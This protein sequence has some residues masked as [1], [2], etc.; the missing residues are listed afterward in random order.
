MTYKSSDIYQLRRW[1]AMDELFRRRPYKYSRLEMD[2]KLKEIYAIGVSRDTFYKDINSLNSIFN[3][4]IQIIN[5]LDSKK[6][7]YEDHRQSILN[8]SIDRDSSNHLRLLLKLVKDDLEQPVFD[9]TKAIIDAICNYE[10]TDLEITEADISKKHDKSIILGNDVPENKIFFNEIFSAITTKQALRITYQ[11]F[12]KEAEIKTL[13]PLGFKKHNNNWYFI[14]RDHSIDDKKNPKIYKLS[15]VVKINLL[16][17]E[18]QH[19]PNFS[20]KEYFKYSIGIFQINIEE[21]IELK[22]LI[23]GEI[24]V[25]RFYENPFVQDVKYTNIQANSV[26]AEM[27]VFNSYELMNE[28]FSYGLNIKIIGPENFIPKYIKELKDRIGAYE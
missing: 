4:K 24:N 6:W 20:L 9:K 28:L 26:I 22:I 25:N 2:E 23:E 19:Q 17:G 11:N 21:P 15:K 8:Y 7:H 3:D 13:S 27:L 10:I 12:N 16:D 14:A 1:I 18:Y 5:D